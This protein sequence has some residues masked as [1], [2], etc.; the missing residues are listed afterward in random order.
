M[1]LIVNS[2]DVPLKESIILPCSQKKSKFDVPDVS[3]DHGD[4]VLK[5]LNTVDSDVD[6]DPLSVETAGS[7]LGSP[8]ATPLSG[9]SPNTT[10]TSD[11]S[12]EG[13]NHGNGN[14]LPSPADATSND[15]ER[16]NPKGT[17]FILPMFNKC[18]RHR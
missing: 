13:S 16:E 17:Y 10:P 2:A 1:P 18:K 4:F 3:A 12:E 15:P 8:P 9:I 5:D 14:P 11:N 6:L 7:S